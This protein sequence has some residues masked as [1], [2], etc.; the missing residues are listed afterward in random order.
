MARIWLLSVAALCAGAASAQD[1]LADCPEF[2]AEAAETTRWEAMR[3]P[4]MLV[5]RAI[6]R[7]NGDEAFALTISRESP[8]RPRRGDRAEV[9]TLGGKEVQWYRGEV[10][11]EPNVLIRE[12]LIRIAEE[13]VV[14]VYMRTTDP[15]VLAARQQIVLSLPLTVYEED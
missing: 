11:N 15:Q 1:T 9:G 6:Q 8:F 12:T 7:D 2:P 13:R 4:G 14:H 5:C 3:V 10:P